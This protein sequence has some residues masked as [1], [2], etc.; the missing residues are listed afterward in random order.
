[1]L[2]RQAGQAICDHY[3]APGAD[4]Y[5]SKGDESPLTQ[6]DIASHHILADGLAEI[7]PDLPILSEE[8]S[9]EDK[10]RRREWPV[11]W[12][13]DPLDGTKE[14]LARTGEFTVNIA[15]IEDHS[16]VLGLIYLPLTGDAYLGIPGEFARRYQ[17]P[18]WRYSELATRPLAEGEA[19]TILASRRHRGPR[20]QSS[21]DWLEQ[22]WGDLERDNSGSALKFCQLSA[23]EGDFYPRYSPCCEWDTAAGQALL[24]AAGGAL[25]GLDGEPL[26][27]NRR[28]T[29]L[30]PHFLAIADPTHAIWQQL[31]SREAN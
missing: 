24:E 27:Y 19:M 25:L 14:F 4:Q 5:R 3:H 29:L 26:Q 2:C 12:L 16:P 28:D 9:E 30:S 15:L 6:A 21:L 20:L 1:M 31:L 10:A 11:Y 13:V 23:G 8:S 18:D 17:G 22:E 7:T